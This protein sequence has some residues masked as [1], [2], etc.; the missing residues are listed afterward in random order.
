MGGVNI[1]LGGDG[2]WESAGKMS[3]RIRLEQAWRIM[4]DLACCSRRWETMA[5]AL[6]S[7][8]LGNQANCLA[9]E[10]LCPLHV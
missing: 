10:A 3:L 4:S 7:I 9:P 2:K 5:W 8:P 6:I 1:F